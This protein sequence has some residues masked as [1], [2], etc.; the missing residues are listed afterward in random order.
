MRVYLGSGHLV[1]SQTNLWNQLEAHLDRGL[2]LT[3]HLQAAIPLRRVSQHGQEPLGTSLSQRLGVIPVHWVLM[4]WQ[5]PEITSQYKNHIFN[6]WNGASEVKTHLWSFQSCFPHCAPW[7]HKKWSD[8]CLWSSHKQRC[9][10]KHMILWLFLK[11]FLTGWAIRN[12][13]GPAPLC[14]KK[15]NCITRSGHQQG[16]SCAGCGAWADE[17]WYHNPSTPGLEWGLHGDLNSTRFFKVLPLAP[18]MFFN[19]V[20]TKGWGKG[21]FLQ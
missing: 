6:K 2:F 9:C 3:S 7:G 17:S 5:F 18:I 8:E 19:V 16:R 15:T 1:P 4:V 13:E 11:S 12:K 10:R 20:L 14:A 21:D